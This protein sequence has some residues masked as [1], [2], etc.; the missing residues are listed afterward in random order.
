[1]MHGH[2]NSQ[3]VS[4]PVSSE[5]RHGLVVVAKQSVICSTD[6]LQR[7]GVDDKQSKWCLVGAC[8]V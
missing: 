3:V 4:D 1:M 6:T 5:L 2:L 7:A 8:T